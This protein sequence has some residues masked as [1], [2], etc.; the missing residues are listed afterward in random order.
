MWIPAGVTALSVTSAAVLMFGGL[1]ACASAPMPTE[2]LAVAEAAVQRA[3]SVSTRESAPAE[4]GMAVDKLARARSAVQAGD[5]ERAR[6][7]AD[8]AA[9]DAQV[10]DI[11]AQTV[12]A[13][14]A[15]RDSEAAARVLREELTRQTPR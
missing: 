15:A 6:R 12:R 13:N 10:A 2:Q 8:E 14:L 4:L 11:R 3:S 7:L 1:A 5:A 9:L